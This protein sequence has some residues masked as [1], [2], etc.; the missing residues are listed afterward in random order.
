MIAESRLRRVGVVLAGGIGQ[1]VGAG[2]PKQLLE[3]A[4]KTILEHTLDVFD[5]H[6][7]IDEVVVVMAPG[8][9]AEAERIARGYPKVTRVVAG[10][11]TRPESTW[12]ALCALGD[13]ECDVLLHDAARPLL[14]PG[15]LSACVAALDRHVAVEV[16]IPSSDTILV[17]EQGPEGEVVGDVPD[18]SRLRR[19][20][21]PQCFRLSVI[22]TAYER[23]FAD[24]EFGA[25]PATDDCGVVLRYLPG[26]PIHLVPGSERNMKVT[27]PVDL[28][29]A[30]RLLG[31]SG[32]A[33]RPL[34]DEERRA[35]LDGRT[36]VVADAGSGLGSLIAG[37]AKGYGA[38]VHVL[39]PGELR[40]PDTG[41]IAEALGRAAA[42]AGRIDY[43]VHAG[44][45]PYGGP[46]A[47]A[48]DRVVDEAVTASCRVPVAVAAASLAH[49]A[50][51]RGGLL[52]AASGGGGAL[53]SLGSAAVTA[54]AR[55]LAGEWAEHGVRVNCVELRPAGAGV[56]AGEP[57]QAP[58]SPEE[59]A[60]TGLDLLLSG[61]SG[62]VAEVRLAR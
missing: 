17:A 43:V 50:E 44:P 28:E 46:L 3:I 45:V 1:R 61:R 54:L 51:T 13:E 40:A 25:R 59:A 23:A 39:S 47:E 31:L 32:R 30:D 42:A 29:I 38:A 60:L 14:D 6:P 53:G 41:A 37:L 18:R 56:P 7:G 24:P 36:L 2:A 10:G 5:G 49:L 57:A 20:Q 55:S 12:R 9:L 11:A 21:T 35:G 62:Q 34:T 58:R 52:F 27:H 15:I 8:F 48:G 22:R 4:G 19:A 26:V 33:V 16:A